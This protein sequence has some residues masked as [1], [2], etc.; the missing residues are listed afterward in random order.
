MRFFK[1][2]L[3]RIYLAISIGFIFFI[4]SWILLDTIKSSGNL[5][6]GIVL[7]II[8]T[9]LPFVAYAMYKLIFK[10]EENNSNSN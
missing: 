5:K 1:T 9:I 8:Y 3:E 6:E 4:D 2:R 7:F 10:K